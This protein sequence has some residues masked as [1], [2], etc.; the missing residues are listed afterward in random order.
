MRIK[1]KERGRFLHKR[2]AFYTC[3]NGKGTVNG[4]KMIQGETILV[5]K[6]TGWIEIRGEMDLF[7]AS[8]RNANV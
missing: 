3:V 6:G 2:F 8:Y 7:L 5:P 4:V 1:V